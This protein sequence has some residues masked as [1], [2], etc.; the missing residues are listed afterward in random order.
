ME[1]KLVDN[2]GSVSVSDVAF[3]ADFNQALVHQVVVAYQAGGRQGSKKQK[4]RGEVHGSNKK[5]WSQKKT[6]NARAGDR[7]GPLWR[8]GGVT[9]AARPQDHS[10]K[11]NKKMY[12]GALRSIFSELARQDRLVVVDNLDLETHKTKNLVAKLKGL[13]LDSVL[14]VDTELKTNVLLASNNLYKVGYLLAHEVDPVSLIKFDKVLL[15]SEA[16]KAIEELLK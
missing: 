13:N 12:K 1:L 10:Q 8:S 11:V 4:T 7:K 16:V 5:P 2:Q 6:G 14:L 3:G 15:T 9:F